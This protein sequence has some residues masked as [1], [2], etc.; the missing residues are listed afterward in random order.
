MIYRN[1]LQGL[2]FSIEAVLSGVGELIGRS[3]GSLI[4]IVLMSFTAVCFI[5]PVAWSLSLL[6][7]YWMVNRKL[8]NITTS[9]TS[10]QRRL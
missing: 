2:G 10:D 4:A 8:A 7:C 5:N 1:T 3:C 9:L 6:Y